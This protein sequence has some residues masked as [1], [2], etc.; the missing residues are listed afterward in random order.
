M[1]FQKGKT[2]KLWWWDIHHDSS[3]SDVTKATKWANEVRPIVLTGQEF[4]GMTPHFY[5]FTS[6]KAGDGDTYDI[7]LLPRNILHKAKELR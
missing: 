7:T 2:Y 1:R 4:L 6:G 3:W 5:I